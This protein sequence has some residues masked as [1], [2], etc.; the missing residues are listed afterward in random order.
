MTIPRLRATCAL[1]KATAL[2]GVGKRDGSTRSAPI[3][4]A[5]L[6]FDPPPRA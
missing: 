3:F 1:V 2:Y 4:R 6:D 5:D